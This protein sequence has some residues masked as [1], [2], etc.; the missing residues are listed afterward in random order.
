M[1]GRYVQIL[2]DR[3][4]VSRSL[5]LSDDR[6]HNSPTFDVS[7]I[8]DASS[9]LTVVYADD[10]IYLD[11][12][13][14]W[15]LRQTGKGYVF[16]RVSEFDALNLDGTMYDVDDFNPRI[17]SIFDGSGNMVEIITE[18]RNVIDFIRWM[19][20]SK[21]IF[22]IHSGDL[23]MRRWE[24]AGEKG[25]EWASISVG[26]KFQLIGEET[27]VHFYLPERGEYVH[28][29]R[30]GDALR[31]YLSSDSYSSM[32]AS[33]EDGWTLESEWKYLNMADRWTFWS[34]IIPR[35]FVDRGVELK[36]YR[37][38]RFTIHISDD[39]PLSARD[40]YIL[41][42]L[43]TYA[44]VRTSGT[45]P[46]PIIYSSTPCQVNDGRDIRC[47]GQAYDQIG[48]VQCSAPESVAN[49]ES[50]KAFIRSNPSYL[51]NVCQDSTHEVCSCYQDDQVYIDALLK[52]QAQDPSSVNAIRAANLLKCASGVCKGFS[53]EIY[54]RDK[55]CNTCIQNIN[56]NVDATSTGKINIIQRCFGSEK[57]WEE[58][59]DELIRMGVRQVRREGNRTIILP[60]KSERMILDT[61]LI[62][63]S[64]PDTYDLPKRLTPEEYATNPG[65]YWNS[66]FTLF[67]S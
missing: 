21:I 66:I 24:T 33:F 45:F 5:H 25:L 20:D 40:R 41:S 12:T 23:T 44:S 3:G 36:G 53:S 2:T 67:Y 26:E 47:Y 22:T 61:D 58:M 39:Q 30:H 64:I 37:K 35:G 27:K 7:F 8:S 43:H 29:N 54:F 49:D 60:G 65:G 10:G 34:G 17:H 16:A 42:R 38:M 51:E 14:Q 6:Y 55:P 32:F 11:D 13:K 9:P 62:F 1:S 48:Y 59:I 18:P 57:S 56:L 28:L 50:C 46:N 15:K 52:L 31:F 19:S 63:T 4:Y